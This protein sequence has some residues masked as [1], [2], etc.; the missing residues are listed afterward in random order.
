MGVD[1]ETI[2]PGDGM[3][4]AL[5]SNYKA[6]C[7]LAKNPLPLGLFLVAYHSYEASN[8]FSCQ[9]VLGKNGPSCRLGLR[10]CRW[11][12]SPKGD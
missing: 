11:D 5:V 12:R 8:P 2:T 1:V 9:L 6:E 3:V 4:V 10:F 7:M